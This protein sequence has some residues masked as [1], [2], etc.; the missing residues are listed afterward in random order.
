LR[1][2]IWLHLVI[3]SWGFTAILGKLIT[4][5]PL[6][7]VIWRAGLA[8]LG[9]AAVAKWVGV[10]MKLPRNEALK[11]LGFGAIIGLHWLLFFLAARLSTA[12]MT[13]SA[14]PTM[15]IFG[16]LLEPMFDK[17]KRW[18]LS[19]LTAGVVICCAV[20]MIYQVEFRYWLG[21]TV[22]LM[23]VILAALFTIGNKQLTHRY[24]FAVLMGWQMLGGC[25]VCLILRPFF[26]EGSLLPAWPDLPD[27]L[28]LLVLA[29]VCTV[30]AYAGYAN[31]LRRIPIFT[32]NVAYNME[33][34]YGIIMAALFF[35]DTEHM[36]LGFYIA[37][38][39]IVASVVILPMMEK[40]RSSTAV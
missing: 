11:L 34:V 35:G 38:S 29:L 22:A 24:H 40:R 17:S 23:S 1:D 39:I 9:F 7:L 25:L 4:L 20:W 15:M 27:F 37:A 5:G 32:L 18:R 14:L 31:L 2:F 19:E 6:D 26:V 21:F 33:P 16:S 8:A 13:L 30:L 10:S 3:L 36:S 28:W 12:S